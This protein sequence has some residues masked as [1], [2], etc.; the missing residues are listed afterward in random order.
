MKYKVCIYYT[1]RAAPQ[2]KKPKISSANN[3]AKDRVKGTSWFDTGH[4]ADLEKC[5]VSGWCDHKHASSGM[6]KLTNTV[7]LC[8]K[9]R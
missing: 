4:S 5:K 9:G 8:L 2:D 1:W 6:E 7:N 3:Y